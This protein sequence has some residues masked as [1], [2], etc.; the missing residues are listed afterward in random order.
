MMTNLSY[1]FISRGK[2]S[3]LRRNSRE[4]ALPCWNGPGYDHMFSCSTVT[5][6]AEGI[7]SLVNNEGKAIGNIV[8]AVH[9][10]I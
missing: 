7:G 10:S 6:I 2:D 9:V 1:A 8:L 3:S 5:V 4:G